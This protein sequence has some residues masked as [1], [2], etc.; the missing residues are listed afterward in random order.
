MLFIPYHTTRICILIGMSELKYV[1]ASDTLSDQL[2]AIEELPS[3]TGFVVDWVSRCLYI[4]E[5][6]KI[7][8]YDTTLPVGQETAKRQILGKNGT[9]LSFIGLAVDPLT[10]YASC[11]SL[12]V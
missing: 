2:F 3:A 7:Y 6:D 4:V 12:Q 1:C 5:F 9:T 10:R 11:Q 8:K